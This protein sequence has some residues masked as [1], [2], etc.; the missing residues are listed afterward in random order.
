MNI[1]SFKGTLYDLL[2][3]FA[4]G[5][6]AW[7][8]GFA[9]FLRL[10]NTP[11]I[12]AALRA[13]ISDLSVFETF[14]IIIAV[15]VLGHGIASASSYLIEKKLLSIIR[16]L[17]NSVDAQKI[18]GNAHYAVFCRKYETIFQTPYDTG[19]IRRVICYVQAKQPAVYETALIFLSF[20]GMARNLAGTSW[21]FSI[22]EIAFLI[23]ARGSLSILILLAGLGFLFLYEYIRFRKYYLE[24]ILS[25]FL[26]PE[27]EAREA[28]S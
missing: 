18:F 5:L 3:Y 21:L 23:Q 8:G 16:P 19:S 20:Y 2:G 4:P 25:G 27:K 12:F 1:N 10:S 24:T 6:V 11:N 7:I 17:R 22:V 13:A 15:Y 26:I 14:V 9:A 28:N